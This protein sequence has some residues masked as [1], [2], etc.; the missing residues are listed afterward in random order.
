MSLRSPLSRFSQAD[1][2]WPLS[3][4]STLEQFRRRAAKTNKEISGEPTYVL[5]KVITDAKD[6]IT[7]PVSPFDPQAF[8][9]MMMEQMM[10]EK[11]QDP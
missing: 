11:Q 2:F 5:L 4:C 8:C 3:S 6:H 1:T 7:G 10:K 9:R